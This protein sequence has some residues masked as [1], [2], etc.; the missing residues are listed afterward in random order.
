MTFTPQDATTLARILRWRRDTRHFRPDPIPE[1]LITTLRSA[2][3]RAPSVG[4]SRP[5]R[6]FRVTSPTLRTAV[7]ACFQ[8]CNEDAAAAYPDARRT[9]YSRLK[10]A[11]LDR[12]P[13]HLAV[14]TETDPPEGHG[15]GRQTL[16]ETLR[17]STAMAIHT[18]WLTARAHN[19]GL[20]MV[21]ILDGA[22]M[23]RL[24]ATP[25]GW[26]FTAYLCLGWPE[27]EDDT[28]L[29]DRVG[30]QANTPTE[31]EER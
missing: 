10:L 4:N 9:A 22:E 31:W 29:L 6:T 2:M 3:D 26:S 1:A 28:P 16:P 21:S 23:E 18:L 17:Q 12:A 15:L 8:R 27:F 19:L 13:L 7:R 25:P 5:W 24:F 20:G 30:W 11:G 14:F